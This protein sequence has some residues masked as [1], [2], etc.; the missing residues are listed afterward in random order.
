MRQPRFAFLVRFG[1]AALTLVA[2]VGDTPVATPPE[3][4][5]DS[6][7]QGDAALDSSVVDSSSP[8]TGVVDA[9]TDAVDAGCPN[10]ASVGNV[11]NLP[12]SGFLTFA[13]ISGP[14]T[15]G[16][17]VLTSAYYN[18]NN[19]S[20]KSAS[21]VGGVRIT[22][23]GPNVTIERRLD[24]QVSGDPLQTRVDRWAG[25]FDQLNNTLK[26]TR[27]CPGSSV[28][29]DWFAVFPSV[30]ASSKKTVELGFGTD[31]QTKT[32]TNGPATPTF[33]FTKP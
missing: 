17:Y 7:T 22:V 13:P 15:S 30:D 33:V 11:V 18:C 8:D 21:A 26:L 31:V 2:C 10:S 24:V 6:S 4:G 25:T 28:S 20:T 1:S 14:M 19:C 12:T 32:T 16:D 23:T 9:T 27:V 3:A 5:V 29:A